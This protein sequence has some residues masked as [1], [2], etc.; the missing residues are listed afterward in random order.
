MLLWVWAERT[1]K[2]KKSHP[3][4]LE[5]QAD[6]CRKKKKTTRK[7]KPNM[8]LKCC[9]VSLAVAYFTVEEFEVL[10][11]LGVLQEQQS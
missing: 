6:T 8:P 1:S 4:A 7:K 2:G 5:A 10:R 3:Q 9:F 11:F